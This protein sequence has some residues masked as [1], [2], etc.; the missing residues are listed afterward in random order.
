MEKLQHI[1]AF[2]RD[3]ITSEGALEQSFG[4]NEQFRL[5]IRTRA[6]LF[7]GTRDPFIFAEPAQPLSIQKSPLYDFLAR[8]SLKGQDI[9]YGYPLLMFYDGALRQHRVAPLFVMRLSAEQ[10]GDEL[11]LA[12]AEP[13]P[14]LGVKAFEKLGLRQEEIAA[15]NTE[16]TEIFSSTQRS[17]L[18]TVLYLLRRETT[19]TF[20]EGIDPEKLS[21]S[22]AIHPYSGAV[23]YNRA[24]VYA[25]EASAYNL[26]ILND[27][28]KLVKKRDLPTTALGYLDS[29]RD[30]SD[31]KHTPVLPFSFDEYQLQ[32]INHI[33]GSKHTVVTGPP[34]TGKSQ[35]IANLIINLFVQKKRVLFVSHTGEAVRVVNERINE[36]FANLMMQTGKKEV[37]QD[38]GRRL[39]EMVAAYNDQQVTLPRMVSD[40][41]LHV[42]WSAIQHETEYLK[43]TNMRQD[44]LEQAVEAR[45]RAQVRADWYGRLNYYLSSARINWQT[46]R[47][48]KRRTSQVVA[49]LV[50]ELKQRHVALSKDYV[51]ANYLPMILGSEQYGK[52]VTYIE[53][54]QSRH[55]LQTGGRDHSDRYVDAAL[56][57]MNIWSCTLK[58]LAA[59][60][61]LKANLFD[62]VIFDEASQIDLPSAAP[63]LYRA[64]RMVVVGDANQLLHI[65]KI[66]ENTEDDLA[67]SNGIFTSSLYPGL[68]GY[69]EASLFN[70]AKRALTEPE[71]QL[72]NHYRSNPSIAN[73]F[74]SIFY[75][76]MLRL[77][78]TERVLPDGIVAGVQWHDIRGSSYKHKNGSRYNLDEVDHIVAQLKTLIPVARNQHLS[79]GVTTP[80]AMQRER[81][82]RALANVYS[83]EELEGVRVLTV[84]Q[85][86]G[87]EVDILLFSTVIAGDGDGGSD[88]WYIKNQQILNVAIS[89]A[90]QSLII[91]GD[92]EHALS[93]QSKLKAIVE[94][95]LQNEDEP[96]PIV[97]NRPMNVFERQLLGLL[98]PLVPK[99]FSLEPQYV[100]DGRYTL[101]FALCSKR[102][103]IAIELDGAQHEIIGGLP[104]F[105]DIARDKYAS[106]KGWQVI[107]I[108]VHRLLKDPDGVA[109]EISQA[110]RQARPA[111]R[112]G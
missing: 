77:R 39:A 62:Y 81:I 64:K 33:M 104:V 91:V 19:M 74:S 31:T 105:E 107:R 73:L 69:R 6:R 24:V 49:G 111:R 63:A 4:V 44:R 92:R 50:E 99:K 85:F 101:D 34:G 18:E 68:I 51:S 43:K 65:A 7:P 22:S 16:I 54:V 40:A 21:S 102:K 100:L 82:A 55:P 17:K 14:I 32:A 29:P 41:P 76:G 1:I 10:H 12:R 103:K 38:L 3:C 47:L 79:V 87:S 97:P 2:W 66:N 13:T 88:Y 90:K 112:E 23:V 71:Q 9:Y 110:M 52:L 67:K 96:V 70:S 56:R 80:Y 83:S 42:N 57:A 106:H 27:L 72:K 37:R 78:T 53:A 86:Q 75:G 20:V 45:E 8:A 15:L 48:A 58:S 98:I 84:H 89:R 5:G 35:F 46:N 94:Y 59:T 60:F 28:E 25:S 61:P 11:V 93:S 36:Q 95:C 30:H 108:P 26:H 109:R